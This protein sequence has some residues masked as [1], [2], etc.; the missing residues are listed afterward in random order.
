MAKPEVKAL[1]SRAKV[2]IAACQMIGEDPSSTLSVR[3]VAARA[4]VSMGSLRH[5]FPTQRALRDAVLETIYDVVAA[6]DQI[7]HDTSVPVRDRLAQCLRQMFAP[8]V[9]EEA[10]QAWIK[11]FEG[12]IVPEPTA[13]TRQA[14]MALDVEGRRRVEHWLAVLAN[15][16]VLRPGDRIQQARFLTTVCTG[17]SIERALPAEDSILHTETETLYAAVDAVLK[18]SL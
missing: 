6:D 11:V 4:G 5:H 8:G 18:T 13:D 10:R 15:E 12:F 14:Y 7:I 2:I 3:A 16:G 1:D 17:L 9:G